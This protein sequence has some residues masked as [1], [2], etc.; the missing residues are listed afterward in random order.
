MHR[1]D[2]DPDGIAALAQ[3]LLDQAVGGWSMGVQGAIAEFTVID[4]DPA[5]VEVRRGPGRTVEALSAGGGLRLTVTD[6]TAAFAAA[7]PTADGMG[8]RPTR[9]LRTVY[10]AVPRRTLPEPAAGLTV[11]EADSEA[12]RPADRRHLL[13]DLAIGHT[14]AAFCVR[15]GDPELAGRLRELEGATWPEVLDR[16][17][18]ALLAASPPR[19]VTTALGR[20]E[21]WAAIPPDQGASP[22]GP[23][24]HLLPPL[25]RTGRELPPGLSLPA[26]LAPAAAFHPPP[27]WDAVWS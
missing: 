20:I 2:L 6:E 10:L 16:A 8:A 11:R 19:V 24:T 18:P 9:P 1:L 3:R 22:D 15:T 7:S 14:T 25:L 17:G 27:G 23:H 4:S 21:V 5:A 12:L 26:D 13:A